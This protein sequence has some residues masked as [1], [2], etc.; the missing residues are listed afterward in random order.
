MTSIAVDMEY[1][2]KQLSKLADNIYGIEME[3][4][5]LEDK[6]KNFDSIW[7]SA[8]ADSLR[9]VASERISRAKKIMEEYWITYNRLERDL[10]NIEESEKAATNQFMI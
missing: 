5:F 6:L 4:G 1:S 8:Q 10:R 9:A 2:K 3:I 7:Q